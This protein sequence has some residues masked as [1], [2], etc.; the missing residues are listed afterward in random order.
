LLQG[1]DDYNEFALLTRKLSD[2]TL[3]HF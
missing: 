2:S 1:H 3:N